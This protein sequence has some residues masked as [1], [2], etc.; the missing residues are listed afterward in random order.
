MMVPVGVVQVGC[1]VT[2]AVGA[3]G[4]VGKTSTVR[5][6]VELMQPVAVFLTVTE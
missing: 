3:A 4:A 1:V 2:D 5:L 6:V